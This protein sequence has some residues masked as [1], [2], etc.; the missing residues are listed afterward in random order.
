MLPGGS[1]GD[2]FPPN[3][4]PL[5]TDRELRRIAHGRYLDPDF[6]AREREQI[7]GR[8]WLAVAPEWRLRRPGDYVTFTELGI[9]LLVARDD[10][11]GIGVFR[12]ACRH[13]G[14]RIATGRGRTQQFR[15]PY[16]GWAYG[17][18]GSCTHITKG[19]GFSEPLK[20]ES[21]GL[22]P[23]RSDRWMGQV[24]INLDP[25]APPLRETL[26][27]LDDELQPYAL[28]QMRPIQSFERVY[29]FNWKAMLENAMDFYHVPFVHGATVAPQVGDGPDLKS[30]GHHTR[31]RLEIAGDWPLRDRLDRACT[32]GG[33]YEPERVRSL[34]KY[35][36]FPNFLINVLPY[37]LTIMQIF[38]VTPTSCRLRYS[39]C[40]RAGAR[41]VEL[42]RAVA[43]WLASRYILRE[44]IRVLRAFQAGVATGAV[45]VQHLHDEEAAAA[46]FHA[47]IDRWLDRP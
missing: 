44:D 29:P 40:R 25:S 10:R 46:H 2:A 41:G 12:N 6:A 17:L 37:H 42:A 33:P 34:H 3:V 24:W 23:V 45:P 47:V 18:D 22:R 21:V 13:R 16:H 36:L 5:P 43:T 4:T 32:R 35:L 8:A 26:G 11:G 30:Y 14:S 28:E 15:C 39:F 1:M 7:F 20:H 9:D 31:Q 27:G 19:D 38:P